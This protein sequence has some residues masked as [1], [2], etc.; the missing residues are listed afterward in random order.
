MGVKY[1]AEPP[2]PEAL[3]VEEEIAAAAALAEAAGA[4]APGEFTTTIGESKLVAQL[5]GDESNG[6]K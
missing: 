2:Q 5:L 6:K 3:D 1:L 4:E